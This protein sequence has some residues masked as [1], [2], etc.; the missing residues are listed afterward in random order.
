MEEKV[1]YIKHFDNHHFTYRSILS[2]YRD[3]IGWYFDREGNELHVVP[4][5]LTISAALE[6]SL[7]DHIIMHFSNNYK[8]EQADLMMRGF[9]SMNLRGKLLN[10][11]PLLT[12][13]KFTINTENKI[14]QKLVNLIKIRNGLVHNQSAYIIHEARIKEDS[15]GNPFIQVQDE[16]NDTLE[17][18]TDL[19]LGIDQDVGQL[20]DALEEFHSLFLDN[21]RQGE[22]SENELVVPLVEHKIDSIE[23]VKGEEPNN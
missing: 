5:V 19:T 17:K 12:N 9:L 20:H 21:V 22:Y 8:K 6:C 16:L 2:N 4:F 11:I 1:I 10:I 7:N 14:Y 18:E 13:N 3:E 23:I 15:D